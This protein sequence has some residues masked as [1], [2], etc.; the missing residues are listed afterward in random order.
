[1]LETIRVQNQSGNMDQKSNPAF[2]VSQFMKNFS[3]AVHTGNPK[4]IFT[5]YADEARPLNIST[6]AKW[7]DETI[8]VDEQIAAFSCF[9]Q[10][11]ES[12]VQQ[13]SCVLDK[14]EGYWQILHGKVQNDYRGH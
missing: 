12:T 13:L 10:T 7:I 8:L 3:E 1:M 11:S 5:Y 2:E 9:L 14:S 4:E 6:D